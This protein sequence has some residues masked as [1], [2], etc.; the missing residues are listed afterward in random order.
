SPKDAFQHHQ[1]FSQHHI[2]IASLLTMAPKW[3]G[4]E[5]VA[6]GK[7]NVPLCDCIVLAVIDVGMVTLVFVVDDALDAF[8]SPFT[9]WLQNKSAKT[10]TKISNFVRIIFSVQSVCLSRRTTPFLFVMA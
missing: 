4:R 5:Y 10:G 3:R 6:L 8:T 9:L 1:A 7:D 2:T